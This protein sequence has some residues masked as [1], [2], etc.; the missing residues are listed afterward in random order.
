MPET[1]IFV[2]DIFT[3]GS[4]TVFLRHFTVKHFQ[5]F[6][7]VKYQMGKNRSSKSIMGNEVGGAV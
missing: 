7:F 2:G 5:Y 3:E 6:R 1:D 4:N